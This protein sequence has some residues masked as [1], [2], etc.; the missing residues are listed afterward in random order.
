MSHYF[1]CVTAGVLWGITVWLP[2]KMLENLTLPQ[3]GRNLA[4]SDLTF[5]AI[6]DY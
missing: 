3:V 5:V 1:D 6:C 2:E 4:K